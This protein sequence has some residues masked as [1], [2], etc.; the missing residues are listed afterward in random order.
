MKNRFRTFRRILIRPCPTRT[1]SGSPQLAIKLAL[2]NLNYRA[3]YFEPKIVPFRCEN[4][5]GVKNRINRITHFHPWCRRKTPFAK[6]SY[7][8]SMSGKCITSNATRIINHHLKRT[9]RSH[10]WVYLLKTPRSSISRISKRLQAQRLLLSVQYRKPL[11]RHIN[12][13][14]QLK[15]RRSG[16]RQRF[17]QRTYRH[18]ILCN[19]ITNHPVTSRCSTYKMTIFIAQRNRQPI[20]LRL[21]NI[22]P[23]LRHRN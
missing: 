20:H 2:V 9:P 6:C 15:N 23:D 22:I 4:V 5:D 13:A 17:R 14:S 19:I 18:N 12:F 3:I 21:Y 8:L 7:H 11:T 16:C 10:L 1:M